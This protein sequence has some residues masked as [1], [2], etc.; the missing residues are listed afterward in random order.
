MTDEPGGNESPGEDP[1]GPTPWTELL[2]DADAIAAE[3][4][5]A[6]WTVDTV[7]PRD[8][9]PWT[10]PAAGGEPR[11]GFVALVDGDAFEDLEPIV[12]DRTFGAAEVYQRP[13]GDVTLALLVERDGPTERAIVIPLYYRTGEADEALASAAAA[14]E[15]LVRVRAADGDDWL[16]FVHDDPSLFD[17]DG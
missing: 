7:E 1:T 8:V 5:E 16:T 15:L 11:G 2:A 4:R 10:E 9:A 3:H 12:A 6:G 14:G 17:V 13:I